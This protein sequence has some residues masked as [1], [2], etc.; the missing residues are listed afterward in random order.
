[1]KR[2]KLA[3]EKETGEIYAVKIIK[4]DDMEKT[5]SLRN[6]CTREI[7]AMGKLLQKRQQDE[8]KRE[9]DLQKEIME[10]ID[11]SSKMQLVKPQPT[12]VGTSNATANVAPAPQDQKKIEG[13]LEDEI[14]LFDSEAWA[15]SKKNP[16]YEFVIKYKEVVEEE[17]AIYIFMELVD[18]IDLFERIEKGKDGRLDEPTARKYFQQIVK[19]VKFIHSTG[20]CHRDLKPENIIVDKKED[21]V[22]ISDFGCSRVCVKKG[23]SLMLK[24]ICGTEHYLAPEVCGGKDYDGFKADVWSLGVILYEMFTGCHPFDSDDPA[25]LNEKIINVQ[26]QMPPWISVQAKD[27]L[28]TILVA[29]P[30]KRATLDQIWDNPWMKGPISAPL[31]AGITRHKPKNESDDGGNEQSDGEDSDENDPIINN[32]ESDDDDDDDE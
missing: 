5:E 13:M 28:Q 2:I 11:K 27:I 26:Y 16:P 29:D 14:V 18:G 1:M 9:K 3:T 23:T 15:A 25:K 30:K 12:V 4:A 17:D 19:G 6:M 8:E 31:P 21:I 22:K 24:T 20:I 10:L 32:E 7:V